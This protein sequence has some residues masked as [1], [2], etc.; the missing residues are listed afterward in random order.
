MQVGSASR[1]LCSS[2]H[3]WVV[4]EVWY[5]GVWRWGQNSE[6]LEFGPGLLVFISCPCGLFLLYCL[7]YEFLVLFEYC[8]FLFNLF[9]LRL[10]II[11]TEYCCKKPYVRNTNIFVVFFSS[12]FGWFIY[13]S[14]FK[15]L[16]DS[17][18][19]GHKPMINCTTHGL[20]GLNFHL[21]FC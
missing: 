3:L 17:I 5:L 15:L 6:V 7:L 11:Y 13:A 4:S 12:S 19:R 9:P 16:W 14:F 10:A 18:T 20:C 21:N 8:I 2:L 1:C